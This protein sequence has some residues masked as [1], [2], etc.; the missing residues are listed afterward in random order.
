MGVMIDDASLDTL[1]LGLQTVG[2]VLG[3]VARDDRLVVHLTI[4]G[5]TPD[6]DQID[7]IRRSLVRDHV[8]YVET[9]D[10]S[11]I[12][13]EVLAEVD[14][15]LNEAQVLS[16]QAVANL[17]QG[18]YNEALKRL[19]TCFKSWSLARESLDKVSRLIRLDLETTLVD[20]TPMSEVI[21]DFAKQLAEIRSA[22]ESKDY[23]ML[24]DTLA[25]EMKPAAQKWRGALEVVK[26][27]IGQ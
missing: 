23:V 1:S 19:G 9:V 10:P 16:D 15:Q 3:H 8:V 20:G 27:S 22:L 18:V 13:H 7:V 14:K 25:F 5:K 17:R 24:A 6:L 26:R 11:A 21:A 12:A 2:D 4:D